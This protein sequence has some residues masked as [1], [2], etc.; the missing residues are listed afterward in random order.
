MLHLLS[1]LTQAG[2]FFKYLLLWLLPN[3]AWMSVDMREP[4][5]A[6]LTEWRGWLG[7]MAF[8]A[9]GVVAIRLL[10]RGGTKGLIGFA[11]IYPWL[12]FGVELAGIRVQEPFVLYRSYLWMPGL[13]LLVPLLVLRFPQSKTWLALGCVAIMLIP[14]AWNR[15]WVFGDNYRLW[16]DA[17]VLL[18]NENVA[19]ADRIYFNRGQALS[20]AHQ[21]EEAAADFKRTATISPQIEPVRY[22]LG[23]AYTNAGRYEEALVEFDAAILI[24]PDNGAAYYAKAFT[25]KRLHRNDEARHQLEQSCKLG[26]SIACMFLSAPGNPKIVKPQTKKFK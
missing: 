10:L 6:T 12:L 22:E 8:I 20:A 2:L 21:W 1:A 26:Y 18:K 14:Q 25:L 16:N 24:K 5:V 19:G 4:F 11:L 23:M 9:Y 13:L 7:A 15:L 17:A 3:A